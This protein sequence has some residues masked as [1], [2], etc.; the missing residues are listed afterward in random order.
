M[1]KINVLRTIASC[2]LSVAFISSVL[3]QDSINVDV[4]QAEAVQN[5]NILS[6]TGTVEAKQNAD[7]APHRSG[8]VEQI[9]VEVGDRVVKGQKLLALDAKLSQHSVT[10]SQALKAA[11]LAQKDE[12][13]RLYHEV[14]KLSK[15]QLVAETL[16]AERLS[17]LEI[18]R[19]NL[20]RAKAELN[21]QQEVLARHTL[22]APF[23]G[24]IAQRQIDVGEWVTQQTAVF[25]LVE[26]TQL[27][28]KLA[29]P[30]EYFKQLNT[31]NSTGQTIEVVVTPDFTQASAVNASLNRIVA[32]A[33]N[34]SRTITGLVDLP[35][36]A[37]LV[38][39]VSASADIKLPAEKQ[40]WV[41][42]PK[43]AI[44]Q[45]PDGGNS[46]FVLENNQAK[47]VL[48][49]V[50]KKQGLQVA[51]T[52]ADADKPFVMSGVELLKDG[53]AVKVN[54]TMGVGI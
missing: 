42:L 49:K 15:K 12:A 45:H 48:V 27:R 38:A 14:V 43:S 19:A 24:V 54:Q 1:L 9:F 40:K 31:A 53:D 50:V 4:Y 29:I 6:L 7:L 5:Q 23:A 35:E 18:A 10:Q 26:Q 33:N 37:N 17:A 41:W 46:V 28:L 2:F 3:A 34:R 36:H 22:Y 20:N 21:Q 13:E 8:V 32:V 39:G 44:K 47:R 16:L 30:Q 25:T 51:I 52:G 11:A